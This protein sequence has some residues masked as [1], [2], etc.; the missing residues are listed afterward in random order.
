MNK[1]IIIFLAIVFLVG[2]VFSIA[3]TTENFINKHYSEPS[4]DDKDESNEDDEQ[5]IDKSKYFNDFDT[6]MLTPNDTN[7]VYTTDEGTLYLKA[8]NCG[9]DDGKLYFEITPDTYE[10]I[11]ASGVNSTDPYAIIGSEFNVGVNLCIVYDIDVSI[12]EG[13]TQEFGIRPDYRTVDRKIATTNDSL[14]RYRNGQYVK[15]FREEVLATDIP[16]NYHFTYI[17]WADGSIDAY[18]DG[19]LI[20]E[21][22]S[23]YNIDCAYAVGLRLQ[24]KYY[25]DAEAEQRVYFDNLKIKAFAKGYDGAIN[26]LYENPDVDLATN[27]DTVLGGGY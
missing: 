5:V 22:D 19:K 26:Y 8:G 15:L 4:A 13:Y 25:N 24:F 18:V 12:D 21:C 11:T 1:F 14:I 17:L 7:T 27:T 9:V 10:S 20:F 3:N 16:N 2:A 23:A 6:L